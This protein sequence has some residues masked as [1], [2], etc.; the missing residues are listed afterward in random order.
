MMLID[1]FGRPIT[2]L[3][4]SVTDRCNLRCVY[5]MPPEGVQWQ[6]HESI[7][8]YEEIAQVVRVAAAEGI[9]E[10]RLTGGEP[11]VRKDL[12]ELVHMIV[13]IPGIE[14]VSLTTN[15]ILLEGQIEELARAGLRRINISL[16]T[17]D[18]EK[19]RRITRGGE[20]EKVW[21]GIAAAE[22]QGVSP[23]KLNMVVLRGVNADEIERMAGLTLDHAWQVRFIELMPIKNQMPWG[24]GFPAPEDMFFPI[25]EVRSR[26]DAMG[27]QSAVP[28][29]GSGPAEDFQLPGARGII[30]FINPLSKAFCQRCNR[31]RL[32]AD[33]NLRPCLLSDGEIPLLA[34]LRAGE[35]I[36]PLIR[37]AV[38]AKPLGHELDQQHVPVGRCMMQIGG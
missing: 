8:R 34:A 28:G 9:R 36:L 6:P 5:C 22:A 27:L 26:L 29:I 7:M 18:A 38:A 35:D 2:Y 31:L 30:G 14:D 25:A 11:L 32:T 10:V 24:P 37:Q 23:I 15:G 17:L 12:H 13:E 33:G 16:D 21:R 1:P 3:R 20:I 4:I 19:F